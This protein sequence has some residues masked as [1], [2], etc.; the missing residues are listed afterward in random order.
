MFRQRV[1]NIILANDV[2]GDGMLQWTE[3]V[4]LMRRNVMGHECVLFSASCHIIRTTTSSF[5]SSSFTL[6]LYVVS[7]Q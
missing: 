1:A 4:D 5:S 6:S 7:R 3:F 2:D